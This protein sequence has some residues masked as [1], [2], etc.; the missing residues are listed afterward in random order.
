MVPLGSEMFV[1]ASI[2]NTSECLVCN[3]YSYRI[4]IMP[5]SIS[6]TDFT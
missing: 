3:G 6:V 4:D 1:E 5:I 2:Q